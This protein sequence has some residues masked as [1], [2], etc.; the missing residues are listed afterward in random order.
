MGGKTCIEWRLV[1]NDPGRD[2]SPKID[3]TR[4]P[5]DLEFDER[6]KEP[7]PPPNYY[8]LFTNGQRVL[9]ERA[10]SHSN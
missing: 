5:G 6:T 2:Y 9:Y 1:H 8:G 10:L 3:I 7:L 4:G